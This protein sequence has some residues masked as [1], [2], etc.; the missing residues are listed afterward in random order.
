MKTLTQLSRT[1][2]LVLVLGL[3][4]GFVRA[5]TFAFSY[6]FGDGLNVTGT[7]SGVAN[8]NF[9]ENV[10]NVAVFFN[11]NAMPGTVFASQFDGANYLNGPVISY[12]ALQ[13]N[14]VFANSDLAGGDFV[15]DSIFYMLNASVSSDTAVAFSSLGYASQDDPTSSAN[16]SLVQ[17]PDQSSTLALLGLA[18]AGL[19]WMKRRF[20]DKNTCVAVA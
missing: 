8:G 12:D 5:D 20:R 4:A 13:N 11:G 17:T 1:L 2:I 16:W 7:F 14:F 9:A 3:S 15:F 18:L 10:F 19:T 6:L